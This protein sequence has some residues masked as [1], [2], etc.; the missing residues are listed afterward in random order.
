MLAK[1]L[2]FLCLQE[3]WILQALPGDRLM[4]PF[5]MSSCNICHTKVPDPITQ[6][7]AP[8]YMYLREIPTQ[9]QT[10]EM[11]PYLLWQWGVAGTQVS[12]TEETSELNVVYKT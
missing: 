10:W 12:I 4:Q 5:Q 8:E 2:G 1:A 11:S 7:F 6:H 3:S 9:V